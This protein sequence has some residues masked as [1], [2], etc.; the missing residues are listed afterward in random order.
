MC[1]LVAVSGANADEEVMEYKINFY[2]LRALWTALEG[3]REGWLLKILSYRRAQISGGFYQAVVNGG[4]CNY[5]Y[6][7]DYYLYK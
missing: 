7:D 4:L 5:V 6:S 1:W 2:F 3:C